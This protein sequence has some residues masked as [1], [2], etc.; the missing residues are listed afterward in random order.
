[1]YRCVVPIC[2]RICLLRIK[3]AAYGGAQRTVAYRSPAVRAAPPCAR[4]PA[5]LARA[6]RGAIDPRARG[7]KQPHA[8]PAATFI[9]MVF[10]SYVEAVEVMQN[11]IRRASKE[12]LDLANLTGCDV[13][14]GAPLLIAAAYLHDH[15]D[16]VIDDGG[17]PRPASDRQMSF[18]KALAG[19]QVVGSDLSMRVASAWIDYHLTVRTIER[20]EDLKLVAGHEVILSHDWVAP[21]GGQYHYEQA[22]VVSSIGANGLVY[23]KGGNGKCAYPHR[24]RRAP[25]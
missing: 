2:C 10:A 23:F 24:L 18:L 4:P 22:M 20:L 11:S 15:L 9:D 6:A 14:P 12:Q 17:N 3:S 1:M 16:P 5:V 21:G 7:A 25:R 19:E 8:S 13:P